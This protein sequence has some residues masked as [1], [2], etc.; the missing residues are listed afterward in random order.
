VPSYF[1]EGG[2]INFSKNFTIQLSLQ[3]SGEQ[4]TIEKVLRVSGKQKVTKKALRNHS[5]DES[6]DVC[7]HDYIEYII[8]H[9]LNSFIQF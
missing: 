6:D 7:L 9:I 3:V 2:A 1:H 8:L 4:K 5:S